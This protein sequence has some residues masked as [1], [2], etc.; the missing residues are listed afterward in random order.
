MQSLLIYRRERDL[1][2]AANQLVDLILSVG[3]ES[4][5]TLLHKSV[6]SAEADKA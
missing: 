4:E 1:S 3:G 5:E 6:H 2:P